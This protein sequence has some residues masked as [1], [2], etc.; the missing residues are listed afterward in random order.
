MTLQE[1]IDYEKRDSYE[2]GLKNGICMSKSRFFLN[3]K[4]FN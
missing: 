2:D 4:I 1:M 3:I